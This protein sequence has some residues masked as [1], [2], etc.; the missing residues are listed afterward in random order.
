VSEKQAKGVLIREYGDGWQA[1]VPVLNPDMA[2]L[3]GVK[4]GGSDSGPWIGGFGCTPEE[5]LS[6]LHVAIGKLLLPALLTGS[7]T[8]E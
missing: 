4:G 6:E 3:P 7:P 5:A 2:R 1:T 8:R